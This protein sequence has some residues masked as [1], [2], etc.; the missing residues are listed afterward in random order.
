MS[1]DAADFLLE[2]AKDDPKIQQTIVKAQNL[3][4][5]LEDKGWRSLYEIVQKAKDR[6]MHELAKRLMRGEKVSPE[7]IAWRRGYFAGAEWAASHP[8]QAIKS[9]ERAATAAYVLAQQEEADS[10][11][12]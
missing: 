8:K 5:L 6:W 12:G 1:A 4:G 3:H 11:H 2:R 7:E 9:L 10:Q